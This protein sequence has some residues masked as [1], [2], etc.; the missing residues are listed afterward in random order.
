MEFRF[1]AVALKI[2]MVVAV[3]G[4]GYQWE[5]TEVGLISTTLLL[6]VYNT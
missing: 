6:H 4:T 2:P 1:A 3:V 5:A